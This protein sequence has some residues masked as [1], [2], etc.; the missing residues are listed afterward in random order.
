MT[1]RLRTDELEW[2]QIDSE[3][4]I[5]DAQD[6]VYLTVKGSGVLIWRMLATSATREEIVGALLD[7]YDVE[8]PRAEED[9]DTFLEM[10][11]RRGLLAT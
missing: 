1:L 7:A 6:A 4:V 8:Q 3:I 9:A 10:L 5:L 2:K 11:S